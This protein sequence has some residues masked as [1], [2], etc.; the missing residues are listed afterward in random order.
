MK[1]GAFYQPIALE[2]LLS[3]A[4]IGTAEDKNYYQFIFFYVIFKIGMN[5]LSEISST[6]RQ[7]FNIKLSNCGKTILY[8]KI[9]NLSSSSKKYLGPG[10]LNSY[11]N[12]DCGSIG[13]FFFQVFSLILCPFSIVFGT[14]RLSKEI[15][16]FAYIGPLVVCLTLV[17]QN[18]KRKKIKNLEK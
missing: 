17:S 9:I 2:N 11:Y 14:Y 3:I 6:I 10:V 5:I 13:S 4:E 18:F 16:N 15:G 12:E 7:E 8:R 1:I